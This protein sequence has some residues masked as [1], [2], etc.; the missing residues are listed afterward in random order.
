MGLSSK[1]SMVD[2]EQLPRARAATSGGRQGAAEAQVEEF[3]Q[4]INRKNILQGVWWGCYQ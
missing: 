3:R 2:E 4:R 1:N